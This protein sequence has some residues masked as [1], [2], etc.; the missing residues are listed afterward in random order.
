MTSPGDGTITFPAPSGVSA[1]NQL[2]S[3]GK[4]LYVSPDGSFFVSGSPTGFDMQVGVSAISTGGTNLLSGLYF[5]SEMENDNSTG[6]PFSYQG[7]VD[8]IP[9]IQNELYHWRENYD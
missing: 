1:A 2:L 8:E 6:G 3:G 5:T 7:A 4:N 9:S